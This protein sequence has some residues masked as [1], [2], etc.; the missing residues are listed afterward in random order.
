MPAK[1]AGPVRQHR[2]VFIVA[3][4]ELRVGVD[5]DD[6]HLELIPRLERAQSRDHVI[7]QVAP[8]AAVDREL[9]DQAPS[10]TSGSASCTPV[11]SKEKRL[12][13]GTMGFPPLVNGEPSVARETL[14]SLRSNAARRA[15]KATPPNC[16]RC[17]MARIASC[18]RAAR[19]APRCAPSRPRSS[20]HASAR[21][22]S[23]P[24]C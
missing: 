10:I 6:P 2:D 22:T 21:P 20:A 8:T 4:G 17:G 1:L 5:V 12:R 11:R 24:D 15:W 16:L 13:R 3:R 7:A 23:R 18:R 19:A 14:V 9:Q